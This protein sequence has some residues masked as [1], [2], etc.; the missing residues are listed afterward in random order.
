MSRG[1]NRGSR[2]INRSTVDPGKQETQTKTEEVVLAQHSAP[3]REVAVD[4]SQETIDRTRDLRY[5]L[6]GGFDTAPGR[7]IFTVFK[8]DSFFDLSGEV[9]TDARTKSS[10]EAINKVNEI[11]S[12]AEKKESEARDGVV[13]EA[14]S[15]VIKTLLKSYENTDGGTPGGSVTFP[16]SRGLKYTDGVSY[17]VVD[18]GL[19]GAAGDIGSASSED[20]RLTGAAKSLAINAAGKALGPAAG[21][22]VGAAL[23]KLGGAALGG[24]GGASIA[25]QTGAIA[26]SATRVSTAPNERTLFERVKLRNFAFS[27]TMIAREAD[28]QLEIKE[29]LKFF[30]SEVY[31]EAIT[32]SGGAPFAYEFPN[33]FQIDIKNRDGTNP[34]FNIQRCYLESVDTTFNGTSSGMFEG[35]EFVEVQVNLSFREIAAMHKGK[36]SKEGF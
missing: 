2:A 19:L 7:I 3:N 27:F 36:V 26:Q 17:N 23:G 33:V 11:R 29:I 8:I 22:I 31:P 4:I 34:G 15:S 25:A 5:P 10:R 18:V 32:I 35:R 12:A 16:L 28:E 14:S 20:G 30:R 21:S 9:D 1:R 24:L 6:N 13:A